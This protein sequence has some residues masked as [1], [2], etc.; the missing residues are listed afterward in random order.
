MAAVL[1]TFGLGIPLARS[2]EAAGPRQACPWMDTSKT[3]D[4]RANLLLKASTLDQELRWLDEQAAN[5]P[6]RTT[7][8]GGFFGGGATYPVQVDCTP[9]V[10]Y[11]DG[12]DYVRGTAGVTIFPDQIG[13][14]ATFDEQLAYDKGVAQADEAFRSGKNV[15]L[16]PGV[17]AS[18]T[19]LSGRT[20]EYL[21]ED[22]LLSGN[23]AAA[24]VNGMQKG[25]AN[26]P[27]MAVIKHYIANE[28]EL[29]RQTS[30]SNLDGRTLR[31]T[32]NLPFKILID[33]SNPGGVMCSYNQVNGVYGCENPI[34]NNVLKGDTGFQGFVTSDFGA[35]HSTAPSLAAGLDQELNAPKFY[36]PANIGA[37]I[38]N[39]SVTRAQIDEAA[40]R[41]VRAY[42]AHGLFDHPLPAVPSTS[43]STDA[44]KALAAQ[45]ASESSVLL[46]NDKNVLPLTASTK[47]IAIIGPTASN[48][49][50]NGVSAGTVCQQAAGP[51]GGGG[52]A[53]PTPVAPL[54]AITARA[55]QAGASVTF[56][57]GADATSAAAT[58][59]AA[60]VAIVFGYSKQGEFADRT[61]LD[62][63]N[64]GDTLIAAV[65][66]ANPRTVAILETGTATPMP[67]LADVKSVVEAWYPGEQQGTAIARLLYGDDNFVGRLPM[68]FPKSLADTPTNSPQQYPGTFANGSTT[69]PTGS[70]EIRQVNFS[71]GLLVGYK[72]YAA[73]NIAPLFPFGHGLSYTGFAYNNLKVTAKT[74]G[75]KPVDVRFLVTNTGPKP[76][77]ETAQVYLT[78]P[79]TTGEPKRLVGYAKVSP[80][81]GRGDKVTLTID[82]QSPDLPLSYYDTASHAWTIAPGTYT[83]EVGP[84]AATA[85]LTGTFSVG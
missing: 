31:E 13:L 27:V 84:S 61:T 53:C 24:T 74:N 22:S 35:V 59:A 79:S 77:T 54:D 40:F 76:G 70:T 60:D 15:I 45:I 17:S 23:M 25:N 46:K 19:A 47:R 5:N 29:D 6:T 72:W 49:P 80:K 10:V 62:L 4:Q 52:N 16:G 82:P 36:T 58:A 83:V 78:L 73:K 7:F 12:P 34:L 11:T 39:G 56:D 1:V 57:N 71:E 51:F 26:Q 66:A 41:V 65:A 2:A 32:Y 81:V 3:A 8:P 43:S 20:P 44:H 63:D 85:T 9:K 18:R 64:N 42:I 33:K 30:S 38:D 14:A 37:A 28:Q 55:A 21:G 75:K 68:T 69:R 67:W 48:T 50:T